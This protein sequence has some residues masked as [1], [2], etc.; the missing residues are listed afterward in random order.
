MLMFSLLLRLVFS[1]CGHDAIQS[2]VKIRKLAFPPDPGRKISDIGISDRQPIR[3]IFDLSSLTDGYDSGVCTYVGQTVSWGGKQETCDFQDMMS[4]E[5]FDVLNTTLNNV[6]NYITSVLNVSRLTSG[7][8]LTNI[9]D[10][11]LLPM[12]VE[13][14]TFITVTTRPF[15]SMSSTI[16]SA[17]YEVTDNETGRPIQGAIVVNTQKIPSEP[18]DENSF[19]RIF[20]TTLLHELIHVL[21]VSYR[22]IPTWINPDTGRPYD[23]IPI[24]EYSSTMYPYK[25]FR[26]LHTKNVQEFAINRFGLEYFAPGVP[27]GLELEDGGGTGT[28]GSHPEARVYID[29]MFV[30][31]T[32]GQNRISQ[33]IFA[34]LADTGWYTVSF[35][36]AENLAW[37]NGQS[38]DGTPL[39][40]FPNSAPQTSFPKHYLCDPKEFDTDVCTFDFLGIASCRGVK[41]DCNLPA[42]ED[43]QKFCNMRNFTD[44]LNL[45]YRGVSE[46]HD[47]LLYKAPYSNSRCSDLSRNE[48]GSIKNGELYGGESMCYM[49]TLSKI[50]YS[51]YTN[52][53]GACYRTICDEN[54]TLT[55][56]VGNVGKVCD[57][58]NQTLTFEEYNGEII[59]PEPKYVCGIREMYGIVGPIPTPV[60]HTGD[61]VWSDFKL[62]TTQIVIISAF[63]VCVGFIIL[64]A[65]IVQY[66]IRNTL[67]ENSPDDAFEQV[68]PTVV[69]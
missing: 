68:A 59:C 63:S 36:K 23:I 9:T 65:L 35:D 54:G 32:I 15:G 61:S 8:Y 60:P 52:A 22:A 40:T 26:I 4:N 67:L 44:P 41:V 43:D 5:K 18:Q 29:D 48:G 45:G 69:N 38:L 12:Y 49:S 51:S 62:D 10:V 64:F 46:L 50:H 34:L 17:Y 31:L 25:I 42:D 3:I 11:N 19:D 39:T 27:A 33:L 20:F 2:R 28:F 66:R 30:G 56:Y 57:H 24:T 13:C 7:F 1:S 21:G 16:A 14:D 55:V 58:E 47:Y 6:N 37:G 53:H